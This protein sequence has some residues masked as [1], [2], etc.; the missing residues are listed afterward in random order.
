[1]ARF[2]HGLLQ[3]V[4]HAHVTVHR[5]RD[6]DVLLGLTEYAFAAMQFAKT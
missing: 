4:R 2:S 6:G 5:C 1:L 3:P